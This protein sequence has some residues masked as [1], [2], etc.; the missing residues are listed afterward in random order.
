MEPVSDEHKRR[1]G[2]AGED[3]DIWLVVMRALALT[4][5]Q[6]RDILQ[7]RQAYLSNLERL[8]QQR[9]AHVQA[10]SEAAPRFHNAF[11]SS[12]QFLQ[13]CACRC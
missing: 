11:H 6:R 10:L 12:Q 7:L 13:A 2:V 3:R 8:L 5:K 4:P 1:T 9:A